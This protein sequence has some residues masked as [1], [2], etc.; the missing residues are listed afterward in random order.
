[1][2]KNWIPYPLPVVGSYPNTNPPKVL[3]STGWHTETCRV[4][5]ALL[6]VLLTR[7]LL[8]EPWLQQVCNEIDPPL[9]PQVPSS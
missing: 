5:G 1:L 4:P 3:P 2:L 6:T 7:K 8:I 9:W